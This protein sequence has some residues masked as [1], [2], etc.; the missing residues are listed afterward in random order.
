MMLKLML[1]LV[2]WL[3]LGSTECGNQAGNTRRVPFLTVTT[4]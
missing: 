3:L 1:I 4:T 2:L